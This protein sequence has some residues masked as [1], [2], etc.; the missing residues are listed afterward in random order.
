M[1]RWAITNSGYS[2]SF[3]FAAATIWAV[4]VCCGEVA[5]A[6]EK[7]TVVE[8]DPFAAA[9]F[10]ITENV[11]TDIAEPFGT[12]VETQ[13]GRGNR[14]INMYTSN[15]GFEPIGIRM[16]G[17]VT[18]GGEDWFEFDKAIGHMWSGFSM[19]RKFAFTDTLMQKEIICL[20]TREVNWICQRP[21]K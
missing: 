20:W 17:T 11:A 6:G 10:T 21:T 4:C 8:A 1:S 19:V 15:P 7:P 16:K 13:M 5:I 12:G 2:T 18:E 3:L 14:A 9:E